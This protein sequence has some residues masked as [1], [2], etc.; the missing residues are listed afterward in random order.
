[1]GKAARATPRCNRSDR[2]QSARATGATE[3]I[4]KDTGHKTEPQ[5]RSDRERTLHDK[6]EVLV[7]LLV[8]EYFKGKVSEG[9]AKMPEGLFPT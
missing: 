8:D 5:K 1:M 7:N 2:G 3:S 4:K 9:K 6:V